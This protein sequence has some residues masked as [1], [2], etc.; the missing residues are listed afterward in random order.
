VPYQ[1]RAQNHDATFGG[2][3]FG[4]R[5]LE[6]FQDEPGESLQG[7]NVQ[8]RVTGDFTI[9]QQL[10]FNLER[11][12]FGREKNQGFAAR[13]VVQDAPDPR[14]A[15]AGFATAGRPEEKLHAHNLFSRKD[16]RAQRNLSRELKS[17]LRFADALISD[18]N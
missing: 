13:I 12:L 9:R 1:Q 18:E 6:F 3:D 10:T 2:K 17:S 14:Q 8:P 5:N 11:G 15:A 16:R 7:Q 4:R